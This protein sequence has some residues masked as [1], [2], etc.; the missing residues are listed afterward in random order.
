MIFIN[1]L[2]LT[3]TISFL[4]LSCSSIKLKNETSSIVDKT[5]KIESVKLI[6]E[7]QKI[8]HEGIKIGEFVLREDWNTD[9][10]YL[11][12]KIIEFAKSKGSNLIEIKTIGWG[13]KGNAFYADGSLYYVNDIEK[14][15]T[16][17][18]HNCSIYIIRDNTES[19]IGSAFTIDLK[20]N[21]T[22]FNDLKK[23]K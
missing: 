21:E 6:A 23:I 4:V 9:W 12:S 10:N 16:N 3:I 8:I 7:N 17:T 20:I 5:K 22:E 11:K 14:V 15:E 2:I 19:P 13:K 18:E 1:K